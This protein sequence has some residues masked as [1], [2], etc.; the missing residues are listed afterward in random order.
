M[1]DTT[2]TC[3][4]KAAIKLFEIMKSNGNTLTN[5]QMYSLVAKALTLTEED[6][7]KKHKSGAYVYQNHIQFG[8]LGLRVMGLVK[9][10]ARGKWEITRQGRSKVS[11]NVDEYSS[12]QKK[13]WNKKI[14]E[15]RKKESTEA[16]FSQQRG[17]FNNNLSGSKREEILSEILEQNKRILDYIFG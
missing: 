15:K 11:L 2:N 8:L 16:S 10:V 4:N 7:Q 12:F 1:I 13:Y 17:L 6:K 14:S 5:R 3:G 9:H